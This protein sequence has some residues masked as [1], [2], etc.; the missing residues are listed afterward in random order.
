[1]KVLGDA[2]F[3]ED[4]LDICFA[5]G[6]VTSP[7]YPDNY[8]IDIYRTETIQV[9]EGLTLLLQFTAF[10]MEP[11]SNCG[12]DYLKIM[13]GDGTILM[14]KSCGSSDDG[15]I[16]IGGQSLGP[17]LPPN[18]TSVSNIVKI[19]FSSNGFNTNPGWSLNWTAVTPG[20]CQQHISMFLA[21]F[22]DKS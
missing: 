6:V 5:T 22:V 20:E 7:N 19:I 8:P 16:V 3:S 12:F 13:D 4:L 11:H 10:N 1:M 14:E 2:D 21:I 15:N 17:S 9:E 18:I